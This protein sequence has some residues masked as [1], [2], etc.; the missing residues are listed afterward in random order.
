MIQRIQSVYLLIALVL[1]VLCLYYM[2]TSLQLPFITLS[3]SALC[4]LIAIFLFKKRKLQMKVIMLAAI[5][6]V[7]F[8]G[9]SLLISTHLPV[10]NIIV[11]FMVLI[12]LLLAYKGVKKDEKL[13][14]SLDRLR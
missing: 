9:C 14:R 2:G 5:M 13:I 11:P 4:A 12:T 10:L 1:D 6:I 3:V 8:Y 7:V